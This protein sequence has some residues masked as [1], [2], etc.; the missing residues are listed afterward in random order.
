MVDTNSF[1]S[2]KG[3]EEEE[4]EGEGE[5]QS[6][7]VRRRGT[8]VRDTECSGEMERNGSERCRVQW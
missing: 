4:G 5:I 8:A 7:V 2:L 1:T 6:A 3:E